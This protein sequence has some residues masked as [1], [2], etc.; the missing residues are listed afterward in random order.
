MELALQI[1]RLMR[2][3]NARIH[4]QAPQFDQHN[5]GP[6]GGMILLTLAEV[7]PASIQTISQLMGR[8]KGQ[9]SRLFSNLE[10]RDLVLRINN[11]A[12]QRSHLLRLTPGG[13]EFVISVK[14]VLDGAVHE[15]LAP[16]DE[17]EKAEMVR[18]LE[19]I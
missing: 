12:D 5:I 4:V 7:Q 15:L 11:P 19:K 10:R 17:A 16:L 8:D 3:L 13:E 1:D 18:L 9:L 2:R 14:Q 6:I